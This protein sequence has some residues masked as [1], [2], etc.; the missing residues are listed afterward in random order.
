MHYIFILI[1]QQA[2]FHL[3]S[4]YRVPQN[5]HFINNNSMDLSFGYMIGL[6]W[7]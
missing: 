4:L 2:V 1:S 5:L 6:D 3:S 7:N